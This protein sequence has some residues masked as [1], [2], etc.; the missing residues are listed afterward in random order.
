[1]DDLPDPALIATRKEFARDLTILRERTGLTVRQIAVRLGVQGAHSTLGD[2]FA[3]RGVPSPAMRDL[4]VRL[5]DFCE[6]APEP[7]LRAWLRVRRVPGRRPAGAEPY[8]GLDCFEPADAE[9]FFGR[10]GLVEVLLGRVNELRAAGGGVQVVV[11]PSGS[12]KSSLLRAGLIASLG[13]GNVLLGTP[14]AQPL[15]DLPLTGRPTVVVDQFEELFTVDATEEE[16]RAFVARVCAA[17]REGA[18]VV[19]G[20]RADF[21]GD[22]LRHADLVA[23]VRAGQVAVGPMNE[24]EL[25]LAIQEPARKARIELEDG[26]VELLLRDGRGEPGALPQLSHALYATWSRSRGRRLTIRDYHDA[27]GIDGAVAASA[28]KVYEE[29]EPAQRELARRLFLDLVH[30]SGDTADTR[31]HLRTDELLAGRAEVEDVLDRFVAQRLITVDADTVRISHEALLTAW[32]LLRSWLEADRAGLVVGRRLEEA[33]TTWRRER[34]DPAALY[35]GTRLASA[36]E[37]TETSPASAD[38]SLLAREFLDAS[39]RREHDEHA[40]ARRRTRL[41]QRLVAGLAVLVLLLAA[42]GGIVYRGQLDLREQRDAALAGKAAQESVALR[43]VD[44][45]LSARVGLAAYRL[46]PS[47]D[48]RGAL[49][50]MAAMPYA[51]RLTGHTLAVYAAGFSPG[52]RLLLS[53]ALDGTVRLY[54]GGDRRPLATIDAHAKGVTAAAF[55][56]GGRFLVTGS[57][58]MTLS[59]WDLSDPRRPVKAATLTGHTLGVRRLALGPDDRTLA[60]SSYDGTVRL[61]DV[62]DPYRPA[63]LSRIEGERGAAGPVVFSPDGRT[64]AARAGANE[65]GLW[66][67]SDPANPRQTRRLKGHAD[68]LLSAAFSPDGRYLATGSFDASVRVWEV[69]GDGVTVLEGHRNGVVAVAFSPDGRTVAGGGYDTTVRLWDVSDKE[70]PGAPATLEGHTDIVY[71]VAFSP[72]GRT[73]VSGGQDNVVRLWDLPGNVLTGH[74]GGVTAAAFSPDGTLLATG[75]HLTARLWR[76][77]DR[78]LLATLR[79]HT[80]GVSWVDFRPDGRYL[81]TA[82]LDFTVRL[83]DVAGRPAGTLTGHTDNVFSADFS[84]GGDTLVSAGADGTVRFWDVAAPAEPR[85]VTTFRPHTGPVLAATYDPAGKVLATA[86][87]D[88]L[89]HLWNP[90]DLTRPL[91]TL[92]GHTASVLRARFSPD[93][94]ALATAGADRTVRLW[95]VHDPARP[96]QV[97]VL[98]GHT[99]NVNGLVF[100]PDGTTLATAGADRTLRL[101]PTAA[102]YEPTVLTAHTDTLHAVDATGRTLVTGSGDATA[103]LWRLDPEE[104]AAEVCARAGELAPADWARH[105]PGLPPSPSCTGLYGRS[106]TPRPA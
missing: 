12:G 103:R 14:G 63:R 46:S 92:K 17:A 60:S 89:V 69:D 30:V 55:L 66:D 93:G 23:A 2:W 43:A 65:V 27:G 90:A 100:T 96:R 59:I 18:V 25:R 78:A 81:A 34:D 64:L 101:W 31:R 8:K 39:A 53:A 54:D 49:L 70:L 98:T 84:P 76:V 61:W 106:P 13:V 104:V 20:V 35:R 11:G 74:T 73:L 22:L 38:L 48:T 19:L 47:P 21:Y 94:T 42:A 105:F 24:A 51:E 40:A 58:D 57:D 6:V 102:P 9:W 68:R 26:L 5:L 86:G 41:L 50:G 1:M 75:S 33:A 62:A 10:A 36:L 32:P 99:K 72:D 83:W 82:G 44:P 71:T 95:D 79:G 97:A 87:S 7:W 91:S 85:L 52:G 28:A 16:R 56:R 37:W 4:F 67:V 88:H 80:D 45:A 77:A 29:L 15:G 3:G